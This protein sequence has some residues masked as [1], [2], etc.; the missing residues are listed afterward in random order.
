MYEIVQ[1][2]PSNKEDLKEKIKTKTEAESHFT[3][4]FSVT[5]ISSQDELHNLRNCYSSMWIFA[6]GVQLNEVFHA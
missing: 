2:L 1:D 3:L 6:I 5:P 4:F